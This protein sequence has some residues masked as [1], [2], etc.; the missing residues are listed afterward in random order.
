MPAAVNG[1][2]PDILRR[3]RSRYPGVALSLSE[4]GPD[5]LLRGLHEHRIKAAILFAPY[6]DETLRVAVR[7]HPAPGRGL[8]GAAP[9]RRPGTR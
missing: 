2:L 9:A 4:R 6:R 8:A 3:Y 1:V 5:D 7:E